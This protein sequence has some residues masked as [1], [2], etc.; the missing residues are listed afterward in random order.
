M[1][2]HLQP[3]APVNCDDS[4]VCTTDACVPADGTCTHAAVVCNDSNACTDDTCVGPTTG[5]VYTNNTAPCS[6]NNPCTTGD[7][8]AGCTARPATDELRRFER[9][10]HRHV[11]PGAGLHPSGVGGA[12]PATTAIPARRGHLPASLQQ[13]PQRELRRRDASRAAGRLD[14]AA[15][16]GP[17][18]R[19]G[20]D[21]RHHGA[22]LRA[23]LRVHGRC[24]ARHRQGPQLGRCCPTV[25]PR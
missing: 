25:A 11:L 10:H 12:A 5:C 7:V 8:C 9:L 4:D 16:H 3:G 23:E 19:R 13:Q 21:H 15:G 18:G 20:V 2:R 14:D 24:R 6:D 22:R 1:T 17:G